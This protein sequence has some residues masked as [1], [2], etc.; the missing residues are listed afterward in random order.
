MATTYDN[1]PNC[2]PNKADYVSNTIINVLM[3]S[4]PLIGPSLTTYY[5]KPV[6]NNK[7]LLNTQLSTLNNS[8]SDWRSLMTKVTYDNT[9]DING[10]TNL[11]VGNGTPGS[12]YTETIVNYLTENLR[13]QEIIDQV[14]IIGFGILLTIVIIYI[15]SIK[16]YIR[17]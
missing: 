12:G 5:P 3:Q 8:I 17:K 13:E 1:I 11:L 6:Q 9:Q 4:I 2:P 15:L 7:D 16:K 10:I 14:N